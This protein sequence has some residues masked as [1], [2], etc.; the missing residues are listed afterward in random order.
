MY[1]FTKK[2]VQSYIFLPE[3]PFKRQEKEEKICILQ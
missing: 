3:K 1:I 2:T